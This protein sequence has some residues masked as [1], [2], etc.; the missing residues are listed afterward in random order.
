M[1]T[2]EKKKEK[3]VR[4][5][6]KGIPGEKNERRRVARRALR[7]GKS[8]TIAVVCF[9]SSTY[10]CTTHTHPSLEKN[11]TDLLLSMMSC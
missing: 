1:K 10:A 9:L 11:E 6:E 3:D 7:L 8:I 2:K 5:I 4:R